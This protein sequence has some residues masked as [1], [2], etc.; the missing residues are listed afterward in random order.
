MEEFTQ[1]LI[2]Y[3]YAGMFISALLA[4]TVFPFNSEMV[5]VGL[6]LT[7]LNPLWLVVWGTLG[8]VA[9]GMTCYWLG[10]I[11]NDQWITRYARVSP[12]KLDRARRFVRGRGAY[13]A[14]FAFIPV[15]GSAITIV[16]GMMRSN[17][18]LTI[19]AMTIGKALRYALCAFAP[20][21]L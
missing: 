15:L 4:G 19:L 12:E 6:S 11:G 17:L 2:Q 13:M 10:T 16:L 3:G 7:G 5:M 18:P 14:F 21:L 20:T 9:G 1:F 8:N